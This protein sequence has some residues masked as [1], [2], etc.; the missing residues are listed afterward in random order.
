MLPPLNQ[1]LIEKIIC[2]MARD[3]ANL[4]C[5]HVGVGSECE[6]QMRLLSVPAIVLSCIVREVYE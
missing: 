2:Q 3:P 5:S 1:T 4:A 6:T